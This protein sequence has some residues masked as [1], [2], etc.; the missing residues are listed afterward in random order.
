[1]KHKTTD[2]STSNLLLQIMRKITLRESLETFL[3]PP[4]QTSKRSH[5]R[6]KPITQQNLPTPRIQYLIHNRITDILRIQ[7][8]STSFL[9]LGFASSNDRR[10]REEGMHHC[11]LYLRTTV[12]SPQFRTQ[13][14]VESQNRSFGARVICDAGSGEE[15]SHTGDGNDMTFAVLQHIGEESL[16]EVVMSEQVY[17]HEFLQLLRFGL[18]DGAL[19]AYSCIVNEDRRVPDFGFDF[20]GDGVD[21]FDIGDIAFEKGDFGVV[22]EVRGEWVYVD[23]DDVDALLGKVFGEEGAEA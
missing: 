12:D 19:T 10:I 5:S 7:D 6:S 20:C 11:S 14:F 21:G 17:P 15:G 1:M 9:K 22:L 13:A 18:E 16:N 23:G 4:R 2:M 3:E 8:F